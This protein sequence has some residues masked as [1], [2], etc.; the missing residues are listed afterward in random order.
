MDKL[1]SN[2]KFIIF[3]NPRYFKKSIFKSFYDKLKEVLEK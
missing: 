3:L 2:E 1:P